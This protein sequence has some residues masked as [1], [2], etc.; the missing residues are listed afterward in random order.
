MKLK[1]AKMHGLGNDFAVIDAIHQRFEPR[2]EL[3][4]RWAD[5]FDGIGFEMRPL[6]STGFITPTA[7]RSLNAVTVLVVSRV[8]CA[9][10]A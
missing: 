9:N 3:V 2:P 7:V 6:S 4:R 1:F 10:R 5:R 8:S